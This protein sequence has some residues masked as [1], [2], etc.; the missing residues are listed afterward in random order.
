M[1]VSRYA[2]F[3]KAIEYGS[4]SKAAIFYNYSQSAVS[5]IISGMEKEFGLKLLK[6]T[7]SGIK[8]TTEGEHLY[9]YFRAL[10]EAEHSV[11]NEANK[12]NGLETGTIRIGTFP[13]VSCH[14]LMPI[15][16]KFKEKYSSI[17]LEM[18]EGDNSQ[19]E[20]WLLRGTVDFGILGAPTLSGFET[21]DLLTDPFVA[22]VSKNH[23]YASE[24]VIPLYVFAQEP[25]VL[26][27]EGTDKEAAGILRRNHITP[28]VEYLSRDDSMILSMISNNMCIGYMGLLIATNSPYEIRYKPTEP[29]F[30]RNI[31]LATN[32][33]NDISSATMK[34]LD[35]IQENMKTYEPQLKL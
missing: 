4:M 12:L 3:L 2:V 24:K 5:Q 20:A 18:F 33:K 10:S 32:K 26:F 8:L 30:Y 22:M 13:S 1:L 19:I 28:N 9:P 14:V 29:Q 25:M 6:R 34:L 17:R 16:K 21:M 11:Y 31:V 27:D 23:K 35:F 7:S 15:L